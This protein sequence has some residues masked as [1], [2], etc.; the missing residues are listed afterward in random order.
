MHPVGFMYKKDD[1]VYVQ[2]NDIHEG[3][4]KYVWHDFRHEARFIPHLR[5]GGFRTPQQSDLKKTLVQFLR[6]ICWNWIMNI[7]SFH[8]FSVSRHVFS[9]NIAWPYR[10]IITTIL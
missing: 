2:A 3:N 4:H 6:G 5:R 1:T 8:L 9:W 7:S 10:C